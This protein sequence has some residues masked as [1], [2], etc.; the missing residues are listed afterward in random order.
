MKVLIISNENIFTY[1]NF[2]SN[3]YHFTNKI[4][5]IE[6]EL[7]SKSISHVI[8]D[9]RKSYGNNIWNTEYIENKLNE[10]LKYNMYYPIKIGNICKKK[11]IHFTYIGEGCIF[12]NTKSKTPDLEVSNNSLANIYCEKILNEIFPDMLYLRIRYPVSGNFIP[13][14]YIIKL[15]SYNKILECNNSITVIHDMFIILE[16]MME[17]K[18]SGIYNFFGNNYINSVDIIIE[19]KNKFDSLINFKLLSEEEHY[20]TIGERSNGVFENLKL[21]KFCNE[22]DIHLKDSKESISNI[23]KKMSEIVKN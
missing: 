17:K 7:I 10:N 5:N 13:H 9:F 19:I 16:K 8:Y 21:Q 20:I 18:I 14:C 3:N 22:N 23:I 1:K 2:K 12:K 4:E 15:I 6:S 11:N